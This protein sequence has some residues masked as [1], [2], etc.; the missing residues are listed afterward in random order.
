VTHRPLLG[1]DPVANHRVLQELLDTRPP[2]KVELPAGR[3]Q[4]GDGLRVPAGW[5]ICGSSAGDCHLVAAYAGGHPVLHVLGSDATISDVALVPGPADPGEHGG[6]RGTGLTIGEYL[7][8]ATPSWISGVTVRDVLVD[9]GDRR[10]ANGVAVMGAVRDV[11][12]QR[13]TVRG[14]YTGLAVHWGAAGADVASI[15]GPTCHPHHLTVDNLRVRNAIEGF[16]LSSVHDVRVRGA[17]L[18]DVEMGFRLLPGDNTDRFAPVAVAPAPAVVPAA[19]TPGAEVGARIE[20]SDVCVRWAGPRYAVRVAGWGRSEV[21]GLVSVLAYR[22]TAITRC[23]LIGAGTGEW[24]PVLMERADG[25]EL[26]DILLAS[27][28]ADCSC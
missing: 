24:S 12:L 3:H 22:D 1:T 15:S 5:T 2:G 17:C 11:S 20:I 4:L 10:T 21:D 23:R 16:Y 14:G 18:R 7:Y 6:D 9:H 8:S 19:F 27:A 25:V 28:G 26:R 13:I